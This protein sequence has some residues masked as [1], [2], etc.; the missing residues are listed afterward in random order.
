LKE[1]KIFINSKTNQ[2]S[3]VL[4]KIKSKESTLKYSD[5]QIEI[6]MKIR[7]KMIEELNGKSNYQ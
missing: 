6:E 5:G 1:R 7:K 2:K 4:P 3:I